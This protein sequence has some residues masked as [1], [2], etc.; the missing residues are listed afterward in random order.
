M[1]PGKDGKYE[2]VIATMYGKND[3]GGSIKDCAV[4]K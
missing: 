3:P 1:V 2:R 4:L